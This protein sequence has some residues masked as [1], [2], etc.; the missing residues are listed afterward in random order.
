MW[1]YLEEMRNGKCRK[2]GE[3]GGGCVDDITTHL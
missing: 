2:I 1:R 3:F